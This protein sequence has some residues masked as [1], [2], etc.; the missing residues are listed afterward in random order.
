MSIGAPGVARRA[1][2][3]PVEVADEPFR[4]EELR[5]RAKIGLP[6]G[7][8]G[9]SPAALASVAVSFTKLR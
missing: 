5:V 2:V 1:R 4:V 3:G 9:E 6:G 8:S 7:V